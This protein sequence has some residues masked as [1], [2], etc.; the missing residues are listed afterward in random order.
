MKGAILTLVALAASVGASGTGIGA[1]DAK[2]SLAVVDRQPLTISGKGFGTRQ[3][4]VLTAATGGE[5]ARRAFRADARGA[6]LLRFQTLRFD[7]CTGL[8]LHALGAAG[9]ELARLKI[10]LRECPGP[11]F[12]P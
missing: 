11:A 10:G 9:T 12:D 4:I 3:R 5:T 2:P 6:F 1:P 7:P 8:S